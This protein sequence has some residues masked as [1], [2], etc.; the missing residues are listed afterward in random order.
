[1]SHSAAN[2]RD[3]RG[4]YQEEFTPQTSAWV[5]A[6]VTVAATYAFFL[7]FAQFG[8]LKIVRAAVGEGSGLAQAILATMAVGGLGGSAW[9][10]WTFKEAQALR[11]MVALFAV[12]AAGAGL[13][14]V[15]KAVAPLFSV[16][17][18]TG[19]GLGG[20]TV[21]L[22]GVLRRVTGGDRLGSAIGLGT[23]AAYAMCNLPIVFNADHTAQ[24]FIAL[25]FC[26]VGILAVQTLDLRAP[27]QVPNSCDYQPP[28]LVAWVMIFLALVWL[29]SGAFSIVQHSPYLKEHTWGSGR[30]YANA[31]IHFAAAILAGYMMDRRWVGRAVLAA[32][33][34]MLTACLLIDPQGQ[35]LAQ[36]VLLY[37]A[38][39]SIYSTAL[40]FY[41]SRASRPK[42][43]AIVYGI[44]GWIG[45]VSGIAM[46]QNLSVIPRWLV[47]TAGAIMLVGLLA[48]GWMLR[49]E[50][51]RVAAG[52][53][54]MAIMASAF[55]AIG[56]VGPHPVGA[57][58][59][60]FF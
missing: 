48:R 18:M 57:Q 14:V 59:I 50:A 29:D 56:A 12:C 35:R 45:S 23:G 24:S 49:R 16:A 40:V 2:A 42:W 53:A 25:G 60:R 11:R 10:G 38:G 13:C 28:A 15:T 27:R 3:D 6:V 46:A 47:A 36:G 31:A 4:E 44:S 26:C 41:P 51:R 8:F 7:L 43:A 9:A 54:G 39:V 5:A 19:I 58:F 22:A 1:M 21:T 17:L 55:S 37:T 32:V 52:L 33:A 34:M 30:L 20:L